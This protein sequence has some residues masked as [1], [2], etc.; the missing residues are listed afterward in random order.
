MDTVD[1][2]NGLLNVIYPRQT[3][4]ERVTGMKLSASQM[5]SLHYGSLAIG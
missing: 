2:I 1:R 3:S 4:M 5:T